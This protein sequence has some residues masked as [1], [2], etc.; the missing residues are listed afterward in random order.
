M[1]IKRLKQTGE[2]N[3]GNFNVMDGLAFARA[4]NNNADELGTTTKVDLAV[5]NTPEALRKA[6]K[7]QSGKIGFHTPGGPD[8]IFT[9]AEEGAPVDSPSELKDGLA[10]IYNKAIGNSIDHIETQTLPTKLT[11]TEGEELDLTGM[12][13]IAVEEDG[14]SYEV[15]DYTVD[16]AGRPLTVEDTRAEVSYMGEHVYFTI[17][18]EAAPTLTSIEVTT[19]PT[20]TTYTAGETFDP[21]GMVVTGHLSNEQTETITDYT[22]SPSEA[23]TTDDTTVTIWY[24]ELSDSINITVNPE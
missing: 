6:M 19:E 17:T 7:E 15:T 23:L 1:A 10:Q 20:K 4:L 22:Y 8:D 16:I 3:Q 18:V 24:Y 5:H 13:V 2:D 12:T 9:H 21:T 11:Y 14:D